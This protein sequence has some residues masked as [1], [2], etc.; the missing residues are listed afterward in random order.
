MSE[1]LV[2][3]CKLLKELLPCRVFKE[4]GALGQRS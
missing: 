4:L 3:L 2:L 1:L